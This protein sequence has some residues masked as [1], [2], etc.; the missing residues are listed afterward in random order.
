MWRHWSACCSSLQ[1]A[2][3]CRVMVTCS[4][5][6]LRT[7]LSSL[8][9]QTHFKVM[10]PVVEMF[11]ID[12]HFL[13]MFGINISWYSIVF[14]FHTVMA[15][16]SKSKAQT[17]VRKSAT[18]FFVLMNNFLNCTKKMWKPNALHSCVFVV[19]FHYHISMSAC[20]ACFRL[21]RSSFTRALLS[22]TQPACRDHQAW[23]VH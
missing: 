2:V 20:N 22:F 18:L 13:V 8:L 6:W 10:S 16:H 12:P 21:Q 17:Q 5:Q 7:A 9:H 14:F 11:M 4:E 15:K 23:R 3:I 1:A 19:C